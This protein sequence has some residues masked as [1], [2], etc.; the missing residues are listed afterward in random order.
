MFHNTSCKL[1]C[2]QSALKGLT[3]RFAHKYRFVKILSKL[4]CYCIEYFARVLNAYNVLNTLLLEQFAD[5]LGVTCINDDQF[6][7]FIYIFDQNL[8][9][10]EVNFLAAA[11]FIL[12]N[13]KMLL[14]FFCAVA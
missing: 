10:A 5:F 13:E 2:R 4:Y 6:D 12:E 11:E 8:K 9:L 7:A 14:I 3:D 1:G